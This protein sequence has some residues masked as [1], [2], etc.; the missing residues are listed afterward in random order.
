MKYKSVLWIIPLLLANLFCTFGVPAQPAPLTPDISAIVSATLTAAAP[1][2]SAPILTEAATI[3]ARD[4]FPATGTVNGQ[5]L[6]FPASAIPSLRISFFNPDGSLQA[7]TD[8]A[9][10][11][12]HYSI[13][14]PVGIYTVVAYSIAGNGFTEGTAGGYTPAVACGLSVDCNDHSLIPITVTAGVTL[15]GINPNDYYAPENSFPPMP[16]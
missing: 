13:D 16:H 6:M 4:F 10:G 3:P 2:I 14:L 1:P 9:P 12:N 7:Y 11:Q 15:D 5:E 8:T